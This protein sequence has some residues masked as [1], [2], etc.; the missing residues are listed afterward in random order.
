MATEVKDASLEEANLEDADFD[1]ANLD[2]VT[3]RAAKIKKAIFPLRRI[4]LDEIRESVRTGRRV[5]M[6]A[7]PLDEED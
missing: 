4:A 1:Y 2:G 3:F 7:V 6:E 5:H